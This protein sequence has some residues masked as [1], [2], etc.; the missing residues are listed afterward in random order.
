MAHTEPNAKDHAVTDERP[1]YDARAHYCGE[2]RYTTL[3]ASGQ[4]ELPRRVRA[5]AGYAQAAWRIVTLLA[6]I[7]LAF[8]AGVYAESGEWR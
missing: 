5:W 8:A 4:P 6:V 3:T 7:V 2:D 1:G